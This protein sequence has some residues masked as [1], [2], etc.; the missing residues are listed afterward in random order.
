MDKAFDIWGKLKEL[1]TSR[2][3]WGI[4]VMLLGSIGIKV[5]GLDVALVNAGDSL[6]TA[7]GALLALVGYIDR[8]PKASDVAKAA[9]LP[10]R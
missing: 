2:T 4:I 9:A 6:V 5:E 10:A 8:R 1:I 3:I 7:A